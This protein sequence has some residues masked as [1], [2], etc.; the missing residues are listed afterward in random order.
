MRRRRPD[1]ASAGTVPKTADPGATSARSPVSPGQEG[2]A[3]T[4]AGVGTDPHGSDVEV[5]TVEPVP[6]QV[7]LRL[8][9]AARPQGEQ[10][11]H[12]RDAVEVDV[13]PHPASQEPA[14]TGPVARRPGRGAELVDQRSA[15]HSRRWT[16]PTR[17]AARLDPTQDEPGG[18]SGQHDAPDRVDE[19]QPAE[20]HPPQPTSGSQDASTRVRATSTPPA[21][22]VSQRR[23]P[24]ARTPTVATT[25]ATW[26][27]S[28]TGAT[29]TL[30]RP[31]GALIASRLAA[32]SARTGCS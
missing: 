27:A 3:G 28:G 29:D 8:D 26:V 18:G 25:W 17:M 30:R 9:R 5:S 21:I 12:G 13:S 14:Y 23:A 15:S 11:G 19:E 7:D 10:T 2:A 31:V 24:M 6:G 4:D 1:H 32:R 22:Q 16:A 20:Q